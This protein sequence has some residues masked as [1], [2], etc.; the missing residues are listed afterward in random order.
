MVVGALG[1]EERVRSNWITSERASER[2]MPY[3]GMRS[4]SRSPATEK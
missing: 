4:A 1:E 2:S 3:F